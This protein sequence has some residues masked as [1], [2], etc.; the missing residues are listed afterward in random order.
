[1]GE[2]EEQII[3]DIKVNYEDAIT[4]IATYRT[5]IDELT[6]SKKNLEKEN[7]NLKKSEGDNSAQMME[8]QKQI[9]AINAELKQEKDAV[10][11]LSKEVQ[12][13]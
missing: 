4:Q 9:E 8:N 10:R 1:M 7:E 2:N 12:N 13:V 5:K 11:E 3:L 6:A